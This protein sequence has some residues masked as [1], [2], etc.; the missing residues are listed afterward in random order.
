VTLAGCGA[1]D[2]IPLLADDIGA[3]LDLAVEHA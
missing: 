2:R 3:P 1:A